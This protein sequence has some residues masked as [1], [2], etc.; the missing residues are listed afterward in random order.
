MIIERNK[1]ATTNIVPFSKLLTI[2]WIIRMSDQQIE[3]LDTLATQ[4]GIG[5]YV[6][7]YLSKFKGRELRAKRDLLNR[8]ID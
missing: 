5:K 1:T 8:I 6:S 3:P 2:F 4:P 7:D